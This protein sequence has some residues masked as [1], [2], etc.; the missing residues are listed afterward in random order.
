MKIHLIMLVLF[1]A[2]GFS[3]S[4]TAHSQ[5][6]GLTEEEKA[7]ITENVVIPSPSDLFLALDKMGEVDWNK[8]TSY[9]PKFVYNNNYLRALNLGVRGADGFIAVQARDKAHL[10]QMIEI[11]IKIAEELGAS[12]TILKKRSEFETYAKKN[13]WF[14][15]RGELDKLRDDIQLELVDQGENDIALLMSIGGW[16]EGLRITSELLTSQ[17]DKDNSTLLYQPI[18]VQYFHK[19]FDNLGGN[20]QKNIVVKQ[21][22]EKIPEIQSLINVGFE[23]PVPVE[24]VRKLHT[25]SS[26]LISAIEKGK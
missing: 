5:D 18:L 15:L 22:K 3:M 6:D 25:I 17:Y 24:N 16:I 21:I 20:A 13:Q 12:D 4:L 19:E 23:E 9:N 10:A 7:L 14:E 26:Q 8:A 1:C 11:I 2:T